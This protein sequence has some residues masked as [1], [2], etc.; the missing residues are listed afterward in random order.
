MVHGNQGKIQENQIKAI[1]YSQRVQFWWIIPH[2][3]LEPNIFIEQVQFFMLSTA[4]IITFNNWP[5]S[6]LNAGEL[7]QKRI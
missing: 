5:M 2:C 1:H 6:S 4:Q 7:A 3:K